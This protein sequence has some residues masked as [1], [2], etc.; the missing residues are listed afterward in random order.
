MA[1]ALKQQNEVVQELIKA[2]ADLNLQ[3]YK[4]NKA[5]LVYNHPLSV[6]YQ[7]TKSGDHDSSLRAGWIKPKLFG[8]FCF[9]HLA[10]HLTNILTCTHARTVNTPRYGRFR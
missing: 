7:V 6:R 5:K 8:E 2:K 1:A 10:V 3:D 9:G 4:G